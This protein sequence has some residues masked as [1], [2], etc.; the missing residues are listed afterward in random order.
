MYTHI[1]IGNIVVPTMTYLQHLTS[2]RNIILYYYYNYM[3]VRA[4]HCRVYCILYNI[5]NC[6][7]VII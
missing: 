7:K 1:G 4:L 2:M 6:D 5:R 3:E